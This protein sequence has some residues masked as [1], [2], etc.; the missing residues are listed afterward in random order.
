MFAALHAMLPEVWCA[1][2]RVGRVCCGRVEGKET[3]G[4]I[5]DIDFVHKDSSLK[6]ETAFFQRTEGRSAEA[7]ERGYRLPWRTKT[8]SAA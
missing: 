6:N 7:G 3:V 5:S 1:F 4:L 8:C 2:G